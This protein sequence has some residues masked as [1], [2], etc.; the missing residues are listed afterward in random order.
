M[1]EI[2]FSSRYFQHLSMGAIFSYKQYFNI[3]YDNIPL[4]SPKHALYH[5]LVEEYYS[6]FGK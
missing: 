3:K 6:L 4:F 1:T 2:I 5:H